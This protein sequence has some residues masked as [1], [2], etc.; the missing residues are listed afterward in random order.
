MNLGKEAWHACNNC[1]LE[2]ADVRGCWL[3]NMTKRCPSHMNAKFSWSDNSRTRIWSL[4]WMRTVSAMHEFMCLGVRYSD[5]NWEALQN[6]RHPLQLPPFHDLG[7]AVLF[8][9]GMDLCSM[10]HYTVAA[11]WTRE[12]GL[13]IRRVW[14]WGGSARGVEGLPQWLYLPDTKGGAGLVNRTTLTWKLGQG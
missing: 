13:R 5:G 14:G 2:A 1:K 8:L 9:G 12:R 4:S 6:V 11:L 7:G 10:D 3:S